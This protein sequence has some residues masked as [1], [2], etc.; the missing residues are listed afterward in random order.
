M[1]DN[2]ALFL[3]LYWYYSV[4]V[5]VL[6]AL[7]FWLYNTKDANMLL[8]VVAIDTINRLNAKIIDIRPVQ[9]FESGHIANAINVTL[10]KAKQHITKLRKG[11][12]NIP[13]IIVCDDGSNSQTL[14]RELKSE[15]Q[16]KCYF[17]SK[18]IQFWKIE[19]LPLV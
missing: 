10:D 13:V 6:M 16:T 8:P 12:D 17:L 15:N 2:I 14:C 7:Q 1:I 19:Q 9:E 3:E 5:V 4:P 18:G 11:K